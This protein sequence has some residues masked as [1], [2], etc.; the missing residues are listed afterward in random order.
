[1]QIPI[2]KPSLLSNKSLIASFNFGFL[3][4]VAINLPDPDMIVKDC[5][6]RTILHA[7]KVYDEVNV[8]IPVFPGTNC[9]YALFE[10]F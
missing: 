9:E 4:T 2:I 5:H 1:M 7:S 3:R 6:E 8:V 10:L